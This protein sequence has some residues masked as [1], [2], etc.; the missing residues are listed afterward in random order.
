MGR[1]RKVYG[2]I[3]SRMFTRLLCIYENP[4]STPKLKELARWQV[5]AE[6]GEPSCPVVLRRMQVS[7]M[8]L[9]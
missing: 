7:E 2:K 4:P 8:L 6:D 3:N 1:A 5:P 9:V